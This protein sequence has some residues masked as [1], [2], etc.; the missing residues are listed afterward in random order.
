MLAS[1]R[2]TPEKKEKENM[3]A[4]FLYRSYN[5]KMYGRTADIDYLEYKDV[6]FSRCAMPW[7]SIFTTDHAGNQGWS[8]G[9]IG[10]VLS[11]FSLMRHYSKTVTYDKWQK[12]QSTHRPLLYVN[13]CNHMWGE[14]DHNPDLIKHVWSRYHFQEGDNHDAL[15]FAQKYIPT[16]WNLYSIFCF[17]FARNGGRCCDRISQHEN[18]D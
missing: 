6:S 10:N 14:V 8:A 1:Q 17:C 11:W 15:E 13:T 12:Y 18:K 2:S 4:T 16:K 3:F 5:R 7:K 9:D